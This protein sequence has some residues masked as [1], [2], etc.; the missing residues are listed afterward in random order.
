LTGDCE[1]IIQPG[2]QPGKLAA[3]ADALAKLT[4]AHKD[5]A[6]SQLKKFYK[7][8]DKVEQLIKQGNS[9]LREYL[10]TIF[11]AN[12]RTVDAAEL[13]KQGQRPPTLNA[14]ALS[15]LSEA[16][17]YMPAATKGKPA[18]DDNVL[19]EVIT[20]YIQSSLAHLGKSTKPRITKAPYEK[21]S[22]TIHVYT[23][24]LK[25]FI[26]AL[27]ADLS[28]LFPGNDDLMSFYFDEIVS[29]SLRE[30][31]TIISS[32]NIHIQ[33]HLQ[34]DSALTFELFECTGQVI[35][36]IQ[37][38][39]S[40]LP[41][42]LTDLV[43]QLRQT[44]KLVFQDLIKYID[45]RVQG[46][47]SLPNDNGICEATVEIISRLA[48]IADYKFSAI[49]ILQGAQN[50]FWIPTPRPTWAEN[51]STSSGGANKSV[52]LLASFSCDAVDALFF[53]L[54]AKAKSL[55]RRNSQIGFFLLTNF[56][57]IMEYSRKSELMNM[58]GP[59]GG[60]RLDRLKKR[61]VNLFLEEWKQVAA[62]LMDVTVV[63]TGNKPLS[64]KDREVIKEKF[65]VF[66]TE[67]DALV[68]RHRSY[69]ISDPQLREELRKEIS[70]IS[71]LYYR[72]YDRHIGGDFS[73]N[74]DKYIKYD[75]Q[76]FDQI[77]N[78]LA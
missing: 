16:L 34:T 75:K 3:Y 40:R 43:D 78:S 65:K 35:N 18:S 13:V 9:K 51:S 24:A 22:N 62:H 10:R 48:R 32:L 31:I 11:A 47:A 57:L 28:N 49:L 53:N 77:L 66:N 63:K 59:N 27:S 41:T 33:S 1:K 54:E 2:P 68:A 55:G 12:F 15:V 5:L 39:S 17:H 71:P 50:G 70:F 74:V 72:F 69:S 20:R 21:G 6:T 37:G 29:Q 23:Q 52:E 56:A 26:T 38:C 58:L 64:S 76:Q 7:V 73:K 61:A 4:T 42:E 45:T 8:V 25:G 19:L 60:E 14:E 44:A 67:F 36:L 30:F 46:L